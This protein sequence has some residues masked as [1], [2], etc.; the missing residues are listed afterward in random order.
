MCNRFGFDLNSPASAVRFTC[1]QQLITLR[2]LF[3][4]KKKQAKKIS[5]AERSHFYVFYDW[6]KTRKFPTARS[7]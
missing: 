1:L 3:A 2:K 7:V 5:N 4:Y 6:E